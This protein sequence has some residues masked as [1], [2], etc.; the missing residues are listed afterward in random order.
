MHMSILICLTSSGT[1]LL[2]NM[3][4]PALV[5][6]LAVSIETGTPI[7]LGLILGS[8]IALCWGFLFKRVIRVNAMAYTWRVSDRLN[9]HALSASTKTEIH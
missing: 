8:F 2:I 6:L 5:R 9:G 1:Y 4:L 7:I 3:S